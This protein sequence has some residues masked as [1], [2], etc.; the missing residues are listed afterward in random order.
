MRAVPMPSLVGREAEIEQVDRFV[1]AIGSGPAALLV[2]GGAGMG[3]TTLWRAASAR[4]ED[5][6]A[7]LLR[8][9]CAEVEMPIAF[10]ALA[11]LLEVAY[12]ELSDSLPGPQGRA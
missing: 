7:R 3:K 6:G 8:S 12:D 11:D 1:A 5:A 2:G 4:A 10:G 9:H